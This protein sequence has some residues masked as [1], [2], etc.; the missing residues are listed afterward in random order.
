MRV[1]QDEDFQPHAFGLTLG[2][3]RAGD[4]G[5]GA[6]A[7]LACAEDW[8]AARRDARGRLPSASHPAHEA[9][10]GS[11][12]GGRGGGE[13]GGRGAGTSGAEANGVGGGAAGGAGEGAGGADVRAEHVPAFLARVRFRKALLRVRLR[14]RP[15]SRQGW[16]QASGGLFI[17]CV[18]C[19]CAIVYSPLFAC[20]AR[21]TL[22]STTAPRCSVRHRVAGGHAGPLLSSSQECCCHHPRR[23]ELAGAYA[24]Q[25]LQSMAG[26]ARADLDA[27]RKQLLAARAEL[28]RLRE[29]PGGGVPAE[30]ALGFDPDANRRLMAPVPPRP[31]Q[32]ARAE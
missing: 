2:D 4:G 8:L 31:I 14:R 5:A 32:V 15:V 16:E 10:N 13:A 28:A 18:L 3:G 21:P 22:G 20:I 19:L 6:L 12:A 23:A 11:A 9:A 1:R 25:G 24:T 26:G 29:A 30:H 7:A 27:A 17:A